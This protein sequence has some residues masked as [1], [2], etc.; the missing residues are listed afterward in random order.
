MQPP[1]YERFPSFPF[2]CERGLFALCHF[3]FCSFFPSFPVCLADVLDP[4]SQIRSG[5]KCRSA[6][7][8]GPLDR[9]TLR[10]RCEACSRRRIKVSKSSTFHDE[11]LA[12]RPTRTPCSAKG[13]H[14]ASIAP[15]ENSRA[16]G[17]R[18]RATPHQFSSLTSQTCLSSIKLAEPL[19]R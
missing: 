9:R 15:R 4:S 16:S 12:A 18:P 14:H 7:V 17:K 1:V 6:M 13:G 5:S 10:T 2:P 3:C 8:L 11:L 19:P